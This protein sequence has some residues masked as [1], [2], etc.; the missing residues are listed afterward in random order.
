M[1]VEGGVTPGTLPTGCAKDQGVVLCP[2]PVTVLADGDSTSLNITVVPTF[3]RVMRVFTTVT[4]QYEADSNAN[5]DQATA[6]VQ[7]RPRP[8]TR[9][10]MP[11]QIP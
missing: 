6:A 2:F 4:S 8:F 9:P 7:V 1:I 3:G 11:L 10:G 5:N